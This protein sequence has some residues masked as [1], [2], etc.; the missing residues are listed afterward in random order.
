MSN[1]K[2]AKA[3]QNLTR[4]VQKFYRQFN[5]AAVNWLLRS[6]FVAHRRGQ[7]PLAGF[8]IPTAILLIL[9][10]TLTVGA[11]TIRA[12]DRNVQV[13]T[14]AQEKVIY[15]AATPAIDRARSKLEFLFDTEKDPR[16]PGGV[17]GESF[18]T[19][20]LVND[21]TIGGVGKYTID[22]GADPYTLT[23]EKRLDPKENSW[24][25]RSD[26]NGDGKADAT[27]VYSV[28]FK[29]PEATA[30]KSA[31]E[32]LLT[33]TD[34]EKA[35]AGIVRNGP[36][37]SQANLT[38][39]GT[40]AGSTSR[41]SGIESGWFLDQGSS[42]I[43]RKNF[44]I[45]T[46]VIPDDPKAATVTLEFQQDRQINRG[47]KWGAWFRYDME[48]FPGPHFNWNGAMHTEGNMLLHNPDTG[49]TA[50]SYT[51]NAADTTTGAGWFEAYLVSSPAS[52]LYQPESSELSIT[53]QTADT[54]GSLGTFNGQVAMGMVGRSSFRGGLAA[55]HVQDNGDASPP[56]RAQL[57]GA[58]DSSDTPT[59]V[60]NIASDAAS[61]VLEERTQ[62]MGADK[63]NAATNAWQAKQV[64]KR[65][66]NKPEK[67][68]FVDDLYRADD[69][70][71]PK[72]KYDSAADG[73]IGG[74]VGT[75]IPSGNRLIAT[76]PATGKSDGNIGLDGYWERRARTE[77]M[78]VLVGERLE[79]G[80]IGGWITPR[81]RN[82]NGYID[83]PTV[84]TS[85]VPVFL[86]D[87]DGGDP[88]TWSELE[89]DPLYP[90][91]VKPY[92]VRL[93]TDKLPHL[94]QQRRSLRDNIPAVQAAAVY[95]AAVGNKDYPVACIAMTVHPGTQHTLRQSINFFPTSF[96]NNSANGGV[97]NT[98]TYL[99]SDFFN[100]RGTDGWEYAPPGGA[101]DTFV[102]QLG[103]GLPLRIAL[104]NL[105]NFA[106]DPDGAFPPKQE[107]AGVIHPYPAL[108]M[109]GNYS[110]LRRALKNLGGGSAANY[111]ALSIADK[112]YIQTA[113][114]SLGMLATNID[115]LQAFDP[116][117]PNNDITWNGASSKVMS[118]LADKLFLLMDGDITNGE[119][120]PKARLATT[121]YGTRNTTELK[122]YNPADYYEVPPEAFIAG[123]KQQIIDKSGGDSLNSPVI[124]MAE[125]IMTSHQVRRDRTFGFRPSPAFGEYAL[126][127]FNSNGTIATKI[128]PS[129]CDPDLFT[130]D[131]KT[132]SSVLDYPRGSGPVE[133]RSNTSLDASNQNL[134]PFSAT[135]ATPNNFPGAIAGSATSVSGRRLALS[136]LCGAIRVPQGYT[137]GNP[138]NLSGNFDPKL[139]PVV[140]PKFPSLYYIFPEVAHDLEGNFVDDPADNAT[141]PDDF[142]NRPGEWD[143]RQPGAVGPN[144]SV[145]TT[146]PAGAANDTATRNAGLNQYDRE[147][148]VIDP[149]IKSTTTAGGGFK[150]VSPAPSANPRLAAYPTPLEATYPT[151]PPGAVVGTV[152]NAPNKPIFS[153]LPYAN[154]SP[155]PTPDLPVSAIA[156]APR[157]IGG[158]PG[159]ASAGVLPSNSPIA[160][161]NNTSPNRILVPTAANAAS[162]AVTK[163][164]SLPTKPWAVPFLDRALFDGRQLQVARV[165]DIDWGMLRSNKP[166]GQS[167]GNTEFSDDREPWLPMSGIVYGFREDAVRED[168]IARPFTGS[169][170]APNTVTT[171]AQL[172][173][174]TAMDLRLPATPIDPGLQKNGISIKPIDHLPDPYRRV[175]GFRMLNGRQLKRNPGLLGQTEESKN[176]R[177]LS[178]FSDQ[179]VYMMGDF[180]LHQ[181]GDGNSDAKGNFLEEFTQTLFADN[182]PVRYTFDTFYKRTAKDTRFA[183]GKDDRWRPS[184]IMADAITMLSESFCDG[185]IAD[186]FVSTTD[187][188]DTAKSTIPDF[189]I[190][191]A[192]AGAKAA[193]IIYPA[194][195]DQSTYNKF[196]LYAPG[197]GTKK[198][199]VSTS[200]LNQNRNTST[201]GL[202]LP[203]TNEGW[204]WKREGASFVA[205]IGGGV[206]NPKPSWSDFTTPI[207][208]G[209]SGEPLVIARPN[210]KA[211]TLPVNYGIGGLGL[212]YKKP[213]DGIDTNA[214][215]IRPTSAELLRMNATV[216]SGITPSRPNQSYGGLHN[217]PR[218]IENWRNAK[219][220]FAGSFL[221][222][223]FS[224]YATS[225]F[226]QKGWE[227]D[228][229]YTT[230]P[231]K[232]TEYYDAP[233]RL[234]GYDVGLQFA[235]AGPAAVRFVSPSAT[236]S[237]FYTEPPV[238]DPYINKLC[239]AAK[240]AGLDAKCVN[241]Q[242]P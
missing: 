137:P 120:L 4:E 135:Y 9:V 92:P 37:S 43:I 36:L 76:P 21:G 241:Q 85:S 33:L 133:L 145:S 115:K 100:G 125:M 240:A 132:K 239:V 65:F 55:I 18:L 232:G 77:G 181:E 93:N 49:G 42:S 189:D 8:V 56:S 224:N 173:P 26:T 183:T 166:S 67:V 101:L 41:S 175:H 149:L 142:A 144:R 180:N 222:L 227:P 73:R 201:T 102:G 164:S 6:A 129:A 109:W 226:E 178:F 61:I 209:R 74:A 119:V 13:I 25:F 7:S 22:G 23:D 103:T 151:P 69:R 188:T 213:E 146:T 87:S 214:G 79:L 167:T 193:E 200:Y 45:D 66:R 29:T 50:A 68:P 51:D 48:I 237:E 179:P 212:P 233:K 96:K 234:W 1:R 91:T 186:T 207:Q 118:D 126:T 158:F 32:Q 34:Q 122:D 169:T 81:D 110:N 184:E 211:A 225:P 130:L 123:L 35:S 217:F 60:S 47:N 12:F 28:I 140:L 121:G 156:L 86:D 80:N 46:I 215:R 174:G 218:F 138:A 206:N 105:A 208:I 131:D 136:R 2:L 53:N 235:P 44:Q 72:P 168:A 141:S 220:I 106:G 5:R 236:R 128:F 150:P 157:Q 89:G 230:V 95:H 10:L 210:S 40:T 90:P 11:M 15:N 113:A 154:T 152:N 219:V 203:T 64:P 202:A 139:R 38:G 20:M 30:G 124:R 238:S 148:Y 171:S 82:G 197:C 162:L 19:G 108:S 147:P 16:Y 204:E 57:T 159:D 194:S 199:G 242:N 94:T 52:C 24:K 229:L 63:T 161:F 111:N 191:N 153:R 31:E 112:T 216:V 62:S 187:P 170:V 88:T 54:P 177:G 70:W 205:A 71:G 58:N 185:S 134:K 228:I 192:G 27:I 75:D 84:T 172:N 116:T 59:A 107:V 98:D 176:V 14:N 114:C 160:A 127:D 83:N 182:N 99:L 3:I 165:T 195:V 163:L 190:S 117:N 39:C 17:P 196:G 78:R 221:Q 198:G 143:H 223:N 231:G 155:F 97:Q 104:D